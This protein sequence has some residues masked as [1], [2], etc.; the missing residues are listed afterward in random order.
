MKRL[1]A[2]LVLLALVATAQAPLGWQEIPG[3]DGTMCADGSPWKFYVAQGDPKKLVVDFQGGGACWN[4]A[5]CSPS[6]STFTRQV[7]P[8]ELYLAQGIYNLASIANPF[9]GWTHVFVPYCTA[10]IHWG[11]ATVK[12]ATATIEHKGAVNAR[13]ALDWTFKNVPA[14]EQVFVTGCS[15]GAYG[16]IMW[17]PY[18]MRQYPQAT[19]RELGDAGLGVVSEA[20][21]QTGFPNWKAEGAIP[22][23]IPELAA[24]RAD[25]SK[26]R[27]PDLYNAFAK[28][29]PNNTFAQY[30]GATDTTQ[31][32][33]YGLMKGETQPTQQTAAEWVQG[34]LANITAIKSVSPN[35][36]SFL[37]PTTQH[38]VIP[39]PE[40]YILK[41]GDTTLLDWI[42][43][44]VKTGQPGDVLPPR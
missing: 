37:A 7:N 36:F 1:L 13:A 20:F 33:F 35:Y 2:L 32:F 12:Y 28:T 5:T 22:D 25:A 15:A 10:D 23:W 9:F 30:S 42:N 31:I 29:Y 27:Q 19:V 44:L 3:P 16:A 41:V 39:R 14:P 8:Q 18:V 26:I 34:A 43:K 4:D 38:C 6:S 11:N 17:A 40:L 24:A 21:V